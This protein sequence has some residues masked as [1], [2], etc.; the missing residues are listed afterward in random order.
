MNQLNYSETL[1]AYSSIDT[2]AASVAMAFSDKN[3][4]AARKI[5]FIGT[6]LQGIAFCIQGIVIS[7]LTRFDPTCFSQVP[8]PFFTSS[9]TTMWILWAVRVFAAFSPVPAVY[10][11]SKRL[12]EVEHAPRDG[13]QVKEARTWNSL[14]STLFSNHFLF[15][16]LIVSQKLPTIL[17][18]SGSLSKSWTML[19]TE[20]GQSAALIIAMAAIG[21]VVY[22]FT[23]LFRM[24]AVE[25]RIRICEANKT[26][27]DWWKRHQS[28]P[29][30]L[31][32]S[33]ILLRSPFGKIDLAI[34]DGL[35]IDDSVLD[36]NTKLQITMTEEEKDAL[37]DEMLGAFRLNDKVG[38]KDCF[39]RGVSM[40]RT[41]QYE[42]YPI[43]MAAR[44]GDV[45]ILKQTHLPSG[46]DRLLSKSKAGD[47]PL[48]VAFSANKLE[49]T[50]W[51]LEEY[52]K[53][54][55]DPIL[56]H[57]ARK[58]VCDLA[59]NAIDAEREDTLK[60]ITDV[61]PEWWNQTIQ[62]A[63]GQHHGFLVTALMQDKPASA[64]FFFKRLDQTFEPSSYDLED[65][66]SL[67]GSQYNGHDFGINL[68]KRLV[69][70]TP[71]LLDTNFSL[72][73]REYSCSFSLAHVLRRALSHPSNEL[74]TDLLSSKLTLPHHFID[75][76]YTFPEF[77]STDGART[78]LVQRG[79]LD[80]SDFRNALKPGDLESI[81]NWIEKTAKTGNCVR[82][83]ETSSFYNPLAVEYILHE[84]SYNKY[85]QSV[86]HVLQ[87]MKDYGAPVHNSY[88]M[89]DGDLTSQKR[90]DIDH[91]FVLASY[92]QKPVKRMVLDM[93]LAQ[94]KRESLPGWSIWAICDIIYFTADRPATE[95]HLAGGDIWYLHCLELLLLKSEPQA[96][97]KRRT[98]WDNQTP[99]EYLSKK[100][101]ESE[102]GHHGGK[103]RW[104]GEAVQLLRPW[105]DAHAGKRSTPPLMPKH[106]NWKSFWEWEDTWSGKRR[107]NGQLL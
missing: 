91:P 62:D 27:T 39:A 32:W 1:I 83:L 21:H 50:Q 92:W 45:S 103:N 42:E 97:Q 51:L 16:S 47:T 25:H 19:W 76:V 46:I 60:I 20:W 85:H 98:L 28:Q 55:Y 17:I 36:S 43:H 9:T 67:N 24:E 95:I 93:A 31:S 40:D 23:R 26:N 84:K 56:C 82:M 4:L 5:L 89:N 96:Y 37:W 14:P 105:E 29:S 57:V 69:Q 106:P 38:V 68:Y 99:F 13:L 34:T 102:Q 48:Q 52:V 30:Q 77:I 61:L 73:F 12:H 58:A 18:V 79:A 65:F 94:E 86:M 64:V 90:M 101:S 74:V 3:V 72:Y 81:K 87:L 15:L 66:Y 54:L 6:S 71:D 8:H 11:L 53:H 80:W 78:D 70:H 49:P 10:R 35:L 63:E 2:T 44:L 41:D 7:R 104:I 22:S 100:E 33:N 59:K 107:R 75:T 88:Y